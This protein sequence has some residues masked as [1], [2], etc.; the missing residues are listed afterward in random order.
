MFVY[1]TMQTDYKTHSVS[2]KSCTLICLGK[3]N[4]KMKKEFLHKL[5][6]NHLRNVHPSDW[7]RTILQVKETDVVPLAGSLD[8]LDILPNSQKRTLETAYGGDMNI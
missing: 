6:E 7:S 8:P 1:V 2:S 5:S 3:L 4:N